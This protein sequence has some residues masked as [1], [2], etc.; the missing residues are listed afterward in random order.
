MPNNVGDAYCDYNKEG[1]IELVS[2]REDNYSN[3][4]DAKTAIINILTS[5]GGI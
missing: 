1:E 2:V 5:Q 3:W 4:E